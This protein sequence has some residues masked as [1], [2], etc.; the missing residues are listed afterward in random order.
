M[1]RLRQVVITQKNA[2]NFRIFIEIFIQII[3]ISTVGRFYEPY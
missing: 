2:K 1:K 3:G